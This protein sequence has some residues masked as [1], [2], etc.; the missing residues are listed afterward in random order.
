VKIHKISVDRNQCNY[1]FTKH[2]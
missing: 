1:W 2:L